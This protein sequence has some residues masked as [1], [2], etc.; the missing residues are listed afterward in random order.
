MEQY[1]L[2]NINKL[3]FPQI[4]YKNINVLKRGAIV[5]SFS[6]ETTIV[7]NLNSKKEGAV[8]KYVTV[9]DYKYKL[10]SYSQMHC[11]YQ[12]ETDIIDK[13]GFYYNAKISKTELVERSRIYQS[14]K[15]ECFP[16]G[17]SNVVNGKF[18]TLP[19]DFLDSIRTN[20][21]PD[22]SE[23]NI[24]EYYRQIEEMNSV[25]PIGISN[26]ELDEIIRLSRRLF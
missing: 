21:Y 15:H 6:V 1:Y 11:K 24:E 10:V 25:G 17:R 3:S 8:F 14:S 20:F 4:S 23:E 16:E 7:R 18:P 9:G 19:K 5:D 26:E 13:G 2:N 12:R 22:I